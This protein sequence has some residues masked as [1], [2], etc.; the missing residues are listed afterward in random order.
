MNNVAI[1]KAVDAAKH[2]GVCYCCGINATE[3]LMRITHNSN[4]W[5]YAICDIC[6]SNVCADCYDETENGEIICL[7]CQK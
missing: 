1:Q 2:Q 6:L 4:F 3:V 5:I 7:N